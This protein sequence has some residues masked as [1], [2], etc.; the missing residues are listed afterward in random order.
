MAVSLQSGQRS[1]STAPPR[2]HLDFLDGI[3][4]LA[5][6]YVVLGHSFLFGFASHTSPRS[7]LTHWLVYVHF[8]VVVF[9]VVSGF[10][11]ALPVI[12]HGTLP[13]GA[14]GFFWRR[15]RRIL[16][17]FYAALLLSAPI[18][19]LIKS[20]HLHIPIGAAVRDGHLV[21]DTLLNLFLLQDLFPEAGWIN[22]PFWS[23]AV[24]WKIYFLFPLFV[25][26]WQRHGWR[27]M[28][29]AAAFI[30]YGLIALLHFL[31]PALIQTHTCPWF[32][33]LFAVGICA[34]HAALPTEQ[35]TPRPQADRR[36]LWA[37]GAL[38]AIFAVLLSL[39]PSPFALDVEPNLVFMPVYDT[40]LGLLTACGLVV[41]A[42]SLPVPGVQTVLRCLTWKPLTFVGTF[43]YSIYLIH[44]AVLP[45]FHI[46]VFGGHLHSPLAA[47]PRDAQF[48]VTV[49][50]GVPTVVALAYLFFLAFERPF[51]NTRR[52]ESHA[53]P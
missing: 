14:L 30:G 48:A 16:P 19:I 28:L 42:K 46:I 10:C 3:R 47:L 11:L 23:V 24:E 21:K 27:V 44:A 4:A 53:A 33:F 2:L 41:L 17:P 22:M 20:Y 12:R 38:A 50:V 51:L 34:A 1:P 15:A 49:L 7:W 45:A 43:A 35:G 18:A 26:L 29:A 52:A 39:W 13:G 8:A 6:L 9:I 36:W 40:V 37:V 32:V 25:W 31:Y 5:A